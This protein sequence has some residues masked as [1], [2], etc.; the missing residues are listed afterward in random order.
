M[1]KITKG[2]I[3]YDTEG[4]LGLVLSEDKVKTPKGLEY[5]GINLLQPNFGK[6]WGCVRPYIVATID[7]NNGNIKLPS[8][9]NPVILP[10]STIIK[11]LKPQD[12]GLAMEIGEEE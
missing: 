10:N 3:C 1:L 2:F 11:I 12:F 8:I 7:T 5:I 4:N 9:T 6:P